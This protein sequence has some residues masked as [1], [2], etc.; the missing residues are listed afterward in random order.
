[1]P[2]YSVCEHG[3]VKLTDHIH[4]SK[5]MYNE[6]YGEI[7]PIPFRINRFNII[8]DYGNTGHNL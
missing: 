4:N 6:V 8:K 5:F 3:V 7:A 1:M 2:S